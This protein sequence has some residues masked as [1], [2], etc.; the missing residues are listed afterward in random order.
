MCNNRSKQKSITST[1]PPEERVNLLVKN[2][3]VVKTGNMLLS[4][5]QY[6]Y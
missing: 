1:Q 2:G 5:Y 4:L 3:L 6:A